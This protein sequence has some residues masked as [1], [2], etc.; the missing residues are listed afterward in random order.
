[1]IAKSAIPVSIDPNL[2]EPLPGPLSKASNLERDTAIG[3]IGV[4]RKVGR[5]E[6]MYFSQTLVRDDCWMVCWITAAHFRFRA[7]FS[8]L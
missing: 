4:L 2:A 6:Q 3:M 7:D 1:M 5:F 8:R